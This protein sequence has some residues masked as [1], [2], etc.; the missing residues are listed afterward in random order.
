MIAEA[1]IR[2]IPALCDLLSEL[3]AQES[4]FQPD[5][6]KQIAGLRLI[7]ENP[8]YGK[9]FV[10]RREGT[11]VGMVNLLL[12]ISLRWGGRMILLEDMIV[13]ADCRGQGLAAAL[14]SHAIAYARSIGA[15]QITLF[16]DAENR[17]AISLYERMGFCYSGNSP[18]RISCVPYI[19]EGLCS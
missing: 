18:M 2:D 15:V 16:T 13:R 7:V 1:S 12:S 3:F 17:R 4:D 8:Q 5:R 11:V 19:A 9:I 10:M 6:D 14:L